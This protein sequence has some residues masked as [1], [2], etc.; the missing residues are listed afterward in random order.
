MH[1]ITIGRTAATL[2]SSLLVGL[3]VYATRRAKDA[4][5]VTSTPPLGTNV[6]PLPIMDRETADAVRRIHRRLADAPYRRNA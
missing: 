1:N 6:I 3:I 5:E 2:A 4:R